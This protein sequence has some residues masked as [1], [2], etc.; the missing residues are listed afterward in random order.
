MKLTHKSI[1]TSALIIAG[2]LLI[3]SAVSA[4]R[5]YQIGEIKVGD[6]VEADP[7]AMKNWIRCTVVAVNTVYPDPQSVNNYTVKCDPNNMTFTAIADTNHIRPA[8]GGQLNTTDPATSRQPGTTRH[9][10]G[11]AK[12][13]AGGP[14]EADV[15]RA[16][17]DWKTNSAVQT[18][19]NSRTT[20]EWDSAIR[21]AAP[22]VRIDRELGKITIYPVKV[23]YT[24]V[25]EHQARWDVNHFTGGIYA[26]YKNAFGEWKF[27]LTEQPTFV[28]DA[29]RSIYK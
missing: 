8:A 19:Q 12:L 24:V 21:E 27:I 10:A 14:S 16:I 9:D 17:L 26:F 4:Q 5:R 18:D 6:H 13:V 20:I 15:K 28:R 2:I 1:L 29:A 7:S 22:S 11:P 23:D 3:A 25:V